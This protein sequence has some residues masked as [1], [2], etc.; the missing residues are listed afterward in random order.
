MKFE[1]IELQKQGPLATLRFNRPEHYNALDERMAPEL[2]EAVMDVQE[3][4][5]IRAMMITGAGPAFHAGGDVK[6]FVA[7]GEGV[8]AYINRMVIPFHAFVSHLVRMPKPVL[9]AVNGTAAGAGF[10]IAM[11]C[12]LV[13]AREDAVFT[14]AYSRIGASPDGSMSY[15]LVRSL[16]MRRAMEL[17]LTNRVLTAQEAMEWGLVNGVLPE[18]NF[19]ADAKAQALALAEGPT[20]AY[21]LAKDLFYHSLNHE[22]ETQMELEAKTIIATSR[23]AD[24]REGTQ[25]FVEK[26]PAAF[27]GR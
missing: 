27:R 13:L 12:D 24:F 19:L 10:S 20:F 5:D 1:T 26:R 11:A 7:A 16:G 2:L 22:L 3:D 17:Y 4:A 9:A 21:G 6:S 25:A 23:T 14:V 15:F 8:S 18:A